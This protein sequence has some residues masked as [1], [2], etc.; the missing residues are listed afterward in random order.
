MSEMFFPYSCFVNKD[1]QTMSKM[2]FLMLDSIGFDVQMM[3][4]IERLC[5][6]GR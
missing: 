3:A 6:C 5:E 2:S 4:W 1:G